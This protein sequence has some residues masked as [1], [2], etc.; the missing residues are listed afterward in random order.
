MFSEKIQKVSLIVKNV[1]FTVSSKF[2]KKLNFEY[3][4]QLL[5]GKSW[6]RKMN[7]TKKSTPKFAKNGIFD[8]KSGTSHYFYDGQVGS[9]KCK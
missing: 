8:V 3:F 7:R 5:F 6:L 1:V 4:F 2:Y 9:I